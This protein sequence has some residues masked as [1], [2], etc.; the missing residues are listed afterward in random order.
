M[1]VSLFC[2]ERVRERRVFVR[3]NDIYTRCIFNFQNGVFCLL[4]V[5][6]Y[7]REI[8]RHVGCRRLL[9]LIKL[10]RET[11]FCFGYP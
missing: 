7:S 4:V 8:R 3:D 5:L 11:C 10:G 6:F 2:I 9:V 1:F